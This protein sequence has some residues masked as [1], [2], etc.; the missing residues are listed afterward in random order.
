MIPVTTVNGL[1][2]EC[3]PSVATTVATPRV[4]DGTLNVAANAPVGLDV[5]GEVGVSP[6][7]L[8]VNVIPCDPAKPVPVTVTVVPT[9]PVVGDSVINEITV[10]GWVAKCVPSVALTV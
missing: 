2:A 5:T 7:P 10:N 1:E 3:V 8:N 4:D 9:G 6:V